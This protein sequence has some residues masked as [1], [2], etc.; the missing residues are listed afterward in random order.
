MDFT[1]FLMNVVVPEPFKDGTSTFRAV[2]ITRSLF[3]CD[4]TNIEYIYEE[5]SNSN[6]T[7]Y[8]MRTDGVQ[9]F[10]LDSANGPYCFGDCLGGSDWVKPIIRTSAGTKLIL[11][12]PYP[13]GIKI[14]SLCGNLPS[15]YL[16]SMSDMNQSFVTVFP[17]PTSGYI[18]FHVNMPNNSEQ[19]EVIIFDSNAREC[20]RQVIDAD[21]NS[22]TLDVSQYSSGNYYY[23]L[24]TKNNAYQ[25]GKFIINK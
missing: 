25:K 4:S 2:Y 18:V 23:T 8:I 5:A 12:R 17:N 24:C 15:T 20:K 10:R 6:R 7:F 16:Y 1:P 3:D 21:S 19:F 14:Y 22:F 13:K 11:Q 9:L